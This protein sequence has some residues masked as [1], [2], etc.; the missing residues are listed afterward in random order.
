MVYYLCENLRSYLNKPLEIIWLEP[1]NFE[2]ELSDTYT[3]T[4]TSS[5][6]LAEEVFSEEVDETEGRVID[7]A[8]TGD[9]NLDLDGDADLQDW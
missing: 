4:S 5:T 7:Q 2:K 9:F 3:S 1:E 6:E 8:C